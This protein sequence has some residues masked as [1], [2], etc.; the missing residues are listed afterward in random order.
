MAASAL[1]VLCCAYFALLA[2]L[3]CRWLFR[4]GSLRVA[5]SRPPT[6]TSEPVAMPGVGARQRPA[7]DSEERSPLRCSFCG[8]AKQ[9]VAKLIAGP[10]VFICDECVASGLRTIRRSC[11]EQWDDRPGPAALVGLLD[12]IVDGHRQAKKMLATAVW[13]HVGRSKRPHIGGDDLRCDV[14]LI[15]GSSPLRGRL[16]R[17]LADLS[18]V[19]L[20]AIDA[21]DLV[22]SEDRMEALKALCL[23]VH[24][25]FADHIV[26]PPAIL[27][28]DNL[29]RLGGSPAS[30]A[31]QRALLAIMRGRHD[32]DWELWGAPIGDSRKVMLI[33]GGD[34]DG[35]ANDGRA[36]TAADLGRYGM[37]RMLADRLT[38]IAIL[39]A[40]D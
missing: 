17:M 34:F 36:F 2:G 24:E 38:G 13:R 10:G 9:D 31:I 23:A 15:G 27:Y 6:G 12:R 28:V 40:R 19:P 18:D 14:L 33:C 37:C 5:E 3:A 39:D 35:L 4:A 1:I 16:I 11:S 20:I 30:G 32:T 25:P 29:D 22:A 26:L 7:K 21:D 8:K